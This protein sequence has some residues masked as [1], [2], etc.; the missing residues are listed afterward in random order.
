MGCQTSPSQSGHCVKD[1]VRKIINAQVKAAEE[2]AVTCV[3]SCERSLHDLLSPEREKRTRHT[4]IPFMLICKDSCKYFVGSG[5][6]RKR[7]AGGHYFKCIE[8]PVFKVRGFARGSRDCVK[9]ELLVPTPSSGGSGGCTKGC[10]CSPCRFIGDNVT[11]FKKTGICITVDL[12]CFCGI[13][14]LD[15]MTPAQA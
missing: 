1:T 7:R 13:S 15:P 14:C 9:L 10:K 12:N 4:T 2:D 8:S 6:I 3:T 5:I 11:G